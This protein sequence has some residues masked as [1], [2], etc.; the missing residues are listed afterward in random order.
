MKKIFVITGVFFTLIIIFLK[1]DS[2]ELIKTHNIYVS[3]IHYGTERIPGRHSGSRKVSYV[4]IKSSHDKTYKIY[5]NK[6]VP[7][8]DG[9]TIIIYEYKRHFSGAK[10]Y[11]FDKKTNKSAH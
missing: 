4:E 11:S 1:Y 9:S 3:K 7:K 2:A 10:Y 6:A 5:T 8:S